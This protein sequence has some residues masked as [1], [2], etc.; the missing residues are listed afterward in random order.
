MRLKQDRDVVF[1][2]VRVVRA[3]VDDDSHPRVGHRE[4]RQLCC[5]AFRQGHAEFTADGTELLR[6]FDDALAI[7][8]DLTFQ[9]FD[10]RGVVVELQQPAAARVKVVQGVVQAGPKLSHE[11]VQLGETVVYDVELASTIRIE[12]G[13][14]A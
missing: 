8:F 2:A 7:G 5:D 12:G 14:V 4:R 3:I 10:S 6:E 13:E 11:G 9:S 1:S